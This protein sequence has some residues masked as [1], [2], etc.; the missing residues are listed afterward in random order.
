VLYLTVSVP[1][2]ILVTFTLCA[3]LMHDL[4]AV[5]KFLVLFRQ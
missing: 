4:L 2:V 1:K 5:A 3:Q